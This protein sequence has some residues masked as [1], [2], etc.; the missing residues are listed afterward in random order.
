MSGMDLQQALED[1][2]DD[3]PALPPPVER[4]A[5]GRRALRRRRVGLAAGAAAVVVAV[6]VPVAALAGGRL[7]SGVEPLGSP[8]PTSDGA[9]GFEEPWRDTYARYTRKGEL[10]IRPG[11]EVLDRVD[12]HLA[13]TRWTRSVALELRY[14]GVVRWVTAEWR[15]GQSSSGWTEP[16]GDW[17]DFREWV[18]QEAADQGADPGRAVELGWDGD[19]LVASED[20]EIL[21]QRADVDLGPAFPAEEGERTGAAL[22]VVAGD[23]MLVLFRQAPGEEGRV[24]AVLRNDRETTLDGLLDWARARFESGEGTL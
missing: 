15:R 24:I 18:A 22:V 21:E 17:T 11:A 10:E 9:P 19:G 2:I 14:E 8:T 20:V 7:T 5:A 1:A 16:G 23:R 4:L 12:D 3:G 6:V 13:G